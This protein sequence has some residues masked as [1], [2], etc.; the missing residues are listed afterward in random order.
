MRDKDFSGDEMK[1]VTAPQRNV[2]MVTTLNLFIQRKLY[3]KEILLQY[4]SIQKE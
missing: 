4:P 3:K 1:V 2:L